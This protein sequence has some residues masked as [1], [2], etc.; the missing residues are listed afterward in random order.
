MDPKISVIDASGGLFSKR[1]CALP[2]QLPLQLN[3]VPTHPPPLA[4]TEWGMSQPLLILGHGDQTGSELRMQSGG[5]S[6]EGVERFP[7]Q[8]RHTKRLKQSKAA[9]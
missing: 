5:T 3:P 2:G 1:G 9:G 8:R 6:A 7:R 4:L